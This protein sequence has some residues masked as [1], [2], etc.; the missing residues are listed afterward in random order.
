M[1]APPPTDYQRFQIKVASALAAWQ[2]VEHALQAF[3]VTIIESP[4]SR[5]SA[6]AYNAVLALN[7]KLGM[8]HEILEWRLPSEDL[9]DEWKGLTDKA[10]KNSRERNRLVHWTFLGTFLEGNRDQYTYIV[11]PLGDARKHQTG[12]RIMETDLER[13]RDDFFALQ[14]ELTE[15][16]NRVV[17]QLTSPETPWSP[18]RG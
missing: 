13:M 7:A 8:I 11:T 14:S 18:N 17:P 2:S 4:D 1:T 6:A 15:F 10:S 16:M 5:W 3:F 12:K 9:K